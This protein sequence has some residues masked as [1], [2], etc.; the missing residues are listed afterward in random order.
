VGR[1]VKGEFSNLFLPNLP[2][3]VFSTSRL[4]TPVTPLE[5]DKSDWIVYHGEDD[6]RIER[7]YEKPVFDSNTT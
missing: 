3:K 7:K 5:P 1:G 4:K 6:L 2:E